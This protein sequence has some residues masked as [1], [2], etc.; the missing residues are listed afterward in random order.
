MTDK[1]IDLMTGAAGPSADQTEL[2]PNES[3]VISKC[4]HEGV[5]LWVSENKDGTF[6]LDGDIE[7]TIPPDGR[8]MR[9]WQAFTRD[10]I[11]Y[12]GSGPG[13]SRMKSKWIV[14]EAVHANLSGNLA[15]ENGDI[16]GNEHRV[17]RETFSRQTCGDI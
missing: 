15:D 5:R 2:L 9:L 8:R 6:Q 14:P 16:P 10:E 13:I 17:V 12:V 7:P 11:T 1:A 3:A 4:K